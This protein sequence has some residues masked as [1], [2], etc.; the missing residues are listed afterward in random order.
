MKIVPYILIS[1]LALVGAGS[2]TKDF[3]SIN[4]DPT[5]GAEIAPGQQLTAAAYYLSGGR[6]T[7]YPIMYYFL[8][9]S[10]YVSGAWGMRF[11]G[12]YIRNDFYGERMW[13]IFY[14]RSLKQLID[15]I[16][17]S[18]ND[19]DL[20][21]YIAAGRILKAYIFSLLT[22]AYG[23]VPY[24]QA[25]IAYYG[26]IYTPKYDLQQE[27][28]KDLFKEL[29]E[30]TAQFDAGK[31][32]LLNDI[33]FNGNVDRWKKLANSLR[34]RLGMRLS[35]IDANMAAREVKAAVDAGVMASADD[36]FKII[37]EN[38]GFPDL[39][40]NGL[41][42][43]FHE[44]SSFLYTIGTNTFV[45]Y[46]KYHSDP[47]LSRFFINRDPAGE[48][49]TALTGYM[50]VQSG[51]YWWDNWGDFTAPGGRVIPHANKFCVINRPFV[52]LQA[53]F[54]HMGYA[55]VQFLLAEAAA[56]GWAG[57]NPQQFYHNGIRAAMKQ[58]EMYPGMDPVP[59]PQVDAFVTAHPLTGLPADTVLKH[60][61]M[62]KWVALFPNGYESFANQR[63]TGYPVLEEIEDVGTES[64]TNKV[65]FLRLFYPG[66]EAFNNT[67]NYQEAL[68]RMGGK[69]DWLKPVWWDKR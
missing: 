24:S 14:G 62:Q 43:A 56:R 10:Q 7:G 5:R 34:L 21:N 45:Q 64:E 25:G 41:S 6:E 68:Q 55:E 38:F 13:E 44:E 28:Y 11:G 49:I 30:A 52:Q 60:I 58:L 16:E 63:R 66:T 46:L 69:N 48:D 2:C 4:T 35:K 1:C 20:V 36:N 47:R 33:V 31:Q 23:D 12:K 65:P 32:A 54:L 22:D 3:D 8:P 40:G 39:R 17:R 50:S 57:T 9:R 61:N 26:K 53:S 67:A 42:Q 19:P 59:Q 37:H 29:T 18:K 15:M 27:I 51:L